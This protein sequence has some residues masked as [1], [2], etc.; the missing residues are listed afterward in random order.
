MPLFIREWSRV[1]RVALVLCLWPLSAAAQLQI[2]S[3]GGVV[4]DGQNQPVA[5]ASVVLQDPQGSPIAR[6]VSGTDGRFALLDIPPGAYALTV[7]VGDVVVLERSLTVRGALRT[8]LALRTG[9]VVREAIV[10]TGD[11]EATSPTRP[12]SIA[13]QS[14]RDTFAALPSQRVQ[15]ALANLPGWTS[16]DNGLLHVRGVDDGLL[17]IVDGI[18]IYERVDRLFGLAPTPASIVSMNA[19]NGYIPPEFGFKGGGVVQLRSTSGLGRPWSATIDAGVGGFETRSAEGMASG[20]VGSWA[21][22]MIHATGERSS[23][24]LDPVDPG[25]FHNQGR[26]ASGGAQVTRQAGL[27]LFTASMQGGQSRFEVPHDLEQEDA[28]QDQRQRTRQLL[29]SASWQRPFGGR[30]SAQFSGYAR[31]GVATLIPSLFDTPVTAGGER[32]NVR[33]G[34]LASLTHDRGRHLFK[35]GVEASRLALDETFMFAVTED[36]EAEELGLSEEALEHDL[37]H[38][39]RIDARA[40]PSLL[41][42]FAQDTWRATDR[43]TVDYG[44]RVDRSTL[45]VKRWQVSPRIGAGYRVSDGTIVRGAFMRLFQPP[46]AEYLLLASSAEARRLSPFVTDEVAGGADIEPERQ[47]AIEASV[48]H[49]ASRR[50]RL[51]V[52]GWMRRG[53]DVDD[54]NVFL[55]T[56]VTFPNSVARQRTHGMD[57]RL[58]LLPAG[59]LS[60]AVTYTYTRVTQ[61][62]P[63]NGGL[64]LEDEF[65]DIGEGTEFTPDHDLRH[66]LTAAAAYGPERARW[67]VSGVVRYRT[68]T[69]LEV[70][71][72]DL[73]D[74][75]DRRGAEAVD[76]ETRRVRP[77]LVA[78][79]QAQVDLHRSGRGATILSVWIENVAN[80]TYAY[81]FGNPFSGTHFGAP[82]RA[83]VAINVAF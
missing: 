34:A 64:F 51:D 80:R 4:T 20:P 7:A 77:R 11:S 9:P 62:G 61:F 41:S 12:W 52:A 78:D 30:T 66:A 48:S 50:V 79:L 38:P 5:A 23:R 14:V 59:G 21:S 27:H 2:G 56:T 57:V 43:L 70:D 31:R 68:G 73:D 37:E 53:R 33:T 46:Q 13:G 35:A 55:G 81:N 22:L 65:I 54:P 45:L 67:R 15:G 26:S 63:I 19:I 24:F 39:F 75:R 28:G 71:E 83:G 60:A 29:L 32:R 1:W 44:L 36:G 8:E 72:D 42:A 49:E 25:N 47:S 10:V 82:R 17:Y 76:V 16:E 18:P 69:P 40:R 3:I 74:L 58:D 6:T